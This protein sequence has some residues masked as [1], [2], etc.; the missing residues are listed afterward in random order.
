MSS[1][2]ATPSPAVRQSCVSSPCSFEPLFEE[3]KELVPT[4]LDADTMFA[5]GCRLYFPI[6]KRVERADK[7]W[8]PL[9]RGEQEDMDEVL[10][11]W[12][13]AVEQ[14]NSAKHQPTQR[15]PKSGHCHYYELGLHKEAIK[16]QERTAEKDAEIERLMANLER[17]WK[18]RVSN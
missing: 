8:G 17:P 1:L 12:R 18:H 11:L 13:G 9:S 15:Y 14:G 4:P 5:D 7:S 6:K 10:R 2:D 3:P 16:E